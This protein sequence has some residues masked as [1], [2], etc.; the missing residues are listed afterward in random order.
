MLLSLNWLRE[1]VPYEGSIETLADQLTMLGLEVEAIHRPFASC[2]DVTVG[3]V[4]S[5]EKH[6]NADTLSVCRV[7]VGQAEPL[8][9][10]CGAPNVAAGQHVPVALPGTALPGGKRIKKSAIRGVESC[11][12]ICSESELGLSA[13]ESDGI[14][15]LP[16]TPNPGTSL[17]DALN[18]NDVVLEIGIT[19]NRADCLC[20]LGLARETAMA[21]GLPLTLPKIQM[22]E[23]GPDAASLVSIRIPEPDLCPAYRGRIIQN[24]SVK[25]SPAWMRYR[26][27][28][29]GVRPVSNVVDV[30]NYVMLEFGQ[31]LHAFDRNLLAGGAIEIK[32]AQDGMRFTTL[33]GQER[34][35][36]S[37]DLLIWD[38][39]KPVA[40][41]GVMGG[42]NTEISERAAEVFLESAVFHPATVRKTAR[43]LGI[44]SESSYRFERGVDQPGSAFALDRAAA[45]IA[46][47]ADGRVLQGVASAE[48]KP[49]RPANISF[50]P[51]RAAELLGVAITGDFCRKTFQGLGCQVE[52]QTPDS[53][54]VSPP[55]ARVDLEREI[56]LVEEAARVY[57]MD[58]IPAALPR[59][60]KS[61]DQPDSLGA[62]VPF[63]RRLKLWAAGAGLRETVNYSFVG[64]TELD[65]LGLPGE[66]RVPVANPLSEEQNVM[67]QA[68]APGLLGAVRHNLNQGNPS[69]RL[70]ELAKVFTWDASS[71]TGVREAHRLGIALCGERFSAFPWP[72]EKADYSDLKGLVEHLLCSLGLPEADF[73]P[74]D[75]HP[76]LAPG[77]EILL[78]GHSL[79]F[80][81]RVLPDV[82]ES[83]AAKS[84][85]WM[86]E[87]DAEGLLALTPKH[88]AR[89][90]GLPK[91]PPSRRDVTLVMPTGLSV[92]DVLG[93]ARAFPSDIVENIAVHDL[94]APDGEAKNATFRVTYRH[95]NRTLTD[96]DVDKAHK[97]LCDTL[98]AALPVRLQ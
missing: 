52:P 43:R 42:E 80:L 66:G 68:L 94:F 25:Q 39:A 18:L 10:V 89:F 48:P 36:T 86:A 72:E 61:L 41:A 8:Q 67:R 98:I 5:R 24:V 13:A 38:E 57:G 27:T 96:K 19:P 20:V 12:M 40:L 28:A 45:L 87:L 37:G 84:G 69:L 7:D 76:W 21:F 75:D 91:F 82:A 29:M 17:A 71:D 65:L 59:V 49:W 90:T 56:D 32:R 83:Y 97:A 77:V 51:S 16:G 46:E 9:I 15:A 33:D 88:A 60:L 6:A 92:A 58:R 14:L 70:F 23:H 30:T 11:G 53:W 34:T 73:K 85:L 35:L 3:H 22:R 78:Q 93:A 95:P 54:L 2:A 74:R 62:E 81:G 4:L 63:M 64:Q 44:S 47:L 31:P 50:R 55:P 79:G 26:L 1:F